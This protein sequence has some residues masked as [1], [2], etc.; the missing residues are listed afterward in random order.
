MR[1]AVA[2]AVDVQRGL[3]ALAAEIAEAASLCWTALAADRR[4][5]VFGN[6]GSAAE[7]QHFAAELS[8]RFLR[9]RRAL[10]G[11]ALTSDGSVLTAISNDF[12]FQQVF[13]RQVAAFGLPADVAVGISTSGCSANVIEGLKTAR[14]AGLTT[15]AVTGPD[16]GP[17]AEHANIVL[18]V[19]GSS[20]A[21]IQEGHLTALHVICDL[22]DAALVDGLPLFA[23]CQTEIDEAMRA[24][25]NGRQA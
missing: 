17:M 24:G 18:A 20:T 25:L 11:L 13:A 8:G 2:D 19:P 10:A 5:L 15:I 3:E 21:R 23:D 14:A 16:A 9:N 6:G 7:A 1:R 12:G 4:V 22:V